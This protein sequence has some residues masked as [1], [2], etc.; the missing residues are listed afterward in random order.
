MGKPGWYRSGSNC[1]IWVDDGAWGEYQVRHVGPP[2]GADGL[3]GPRQ[4][5][6]RWGATRPNGLRGERCFIFG[7][8]GS[9]PAVGGKESGAR[10]KC[11]WSIL[12]SQSPVQSS[13][14]VCRIHERELDRALRAYAG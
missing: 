14:G 12:G 1:V 8:L 6:K 7:G 3:N 11:S 4:T 13:V 10:W 2:A 5:S 9:K